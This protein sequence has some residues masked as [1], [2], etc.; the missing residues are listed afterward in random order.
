MPCPSRA[1]RVFSDWTPLTTDLR[2]D[3]QNST[4]VCTATALAISPS[5]PRKVLPV[6]LAAFGGTW[7]AGTVTLTWMTAS[8][9]NSAFFG[10]E[11]VARAGHLPLSAW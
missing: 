7:E 10:V 4:S 11:G 8:E 2:P 6:G 3:A 5:R 9:T 1:R